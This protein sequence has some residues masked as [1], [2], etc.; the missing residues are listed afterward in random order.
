L[1]INRHGIQEAVRY[2]RP[3]VEGVFDNSKSAA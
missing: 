3:A 1:G 2:G